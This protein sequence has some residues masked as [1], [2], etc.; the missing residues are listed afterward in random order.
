MAHFPVSIKHVS[1]RWIHIYEC[2]NL[3]TY[4]VVPCQPYFP[5]S[6]ICLR[7][8]QSSPLIEECIRT[9]IPS[10]GPIHVLQIS[11]WSIC[12]RSLTAELAFGRRIIH[13]YHRLVPYMPSRPAAH[14][15][16]ALRPALC[17]HA[18][19]GADDKN[20]I[21]FCSRWCHCRRCCCS[22]DYCCSEGCR[23][24]DAPHATEEEERGE[25]CLAS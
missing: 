4:M 17:P 24:A 7:S 20:A 22:D 9:Y 21:F 10:A 15:A 23:G 11:D 12:F 8:L 19:H 3:N 18:L 14:G 6:S 13:A 5:D 25:V 1:D 16:A 2:I